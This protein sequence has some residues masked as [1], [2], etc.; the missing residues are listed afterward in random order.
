VALRGL[1]DGDGIRIEVRDGG[2]GFGRRLPRSGRGR[3]LR[4]AARAVEEAGGRLR[5]ASDADG[6]T[7]AVELP[8]ADI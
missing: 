1:R 6:A 4:I 5:V 8:I 7:V 2:P 3:G